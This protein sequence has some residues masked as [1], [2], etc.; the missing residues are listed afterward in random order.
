[1][2][3]LNECTGKTAREKLTNDFENKKQPHKKKKST[4][5]EPKDQRI[6]PVRKSTIKNSI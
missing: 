5:N 4:N 3:K 2:T 6:T 1:M